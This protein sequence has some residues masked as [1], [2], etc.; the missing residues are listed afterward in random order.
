VGPARGAAAARDR[1]TFQ[2]SPESF[3]ATEPDYAV[4]VCEA[5]LDVWQPT[6]QRPCIINLPATVEVASPNVFADQVE[7]FATHISRRDAI[8]LSV[9][10][11]NDRGGARPRRSWPSWR[12]RIGSRGPCSATASAPATW[13][14]SPWR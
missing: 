7:Y 2:Y 4:E 10:T 5:V 1:W 14:S 6:P 9:H 12:A 13:T 3:T 8:V 11:H